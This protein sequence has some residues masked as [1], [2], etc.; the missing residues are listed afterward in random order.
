MSQTK[1]VKINDLVKT[2]FNVYL[3]LKCK[4]GTNISYGTPPHYKRQAAKYLWG[5]CCVFDC[6][7]PFV[8][9]VYYVDRL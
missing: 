1:I 3:K 2:V 4:R 7:D 9:C 6:T 8:I 5:F